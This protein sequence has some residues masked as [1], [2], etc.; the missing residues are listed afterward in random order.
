MR[1]LPAGSWMKAYSQ[2]ALFAHHIWGRLEGQ[3]GHGWE[4]RDGGSSTGIGLRSLTKPGDGERSRKNCC[5]LWGDCLPWLPRRAAWPWHCGGGN[6]PGWRGIVQ[7]SCCWTAHSFQSLPRLCHQ[8]LELHVWSRPTSHSQRL[9]IG[10]MDWAW[11]RK[12]TSR[13]AWCRHFHICTIWAW[14]TVTSSQTT[15][16]SMNKAPSL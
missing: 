6:V 5:R 14:P 8:D 9:A 2:K 11:T 12:I 1:I 4:R 7:G 13:W 15:S 16:W 3:A 10:S